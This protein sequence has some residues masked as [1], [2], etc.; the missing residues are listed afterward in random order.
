LAKLV[1]VAVTWAMLKPSPYFEGPLSWRK[2]KGGGPILINLIHDIDN[3]RYIC[4][5]IK[6]VYAMASHQVRSF[7]VEDTASITLR[8]ENGALGTIFLS[9]CAPSLSAYEATTAETPYIYGTDTENCYHFFGTEASLAF[10]R[11]KRLFYSD[12][13]KSAWNY[14]LSEE[15][16]TVVREED[17]IHREIQA[18]LRS[19]FGKRDSTNLGEDG[20]KTLEVTLA[21]GR[22][23]ETGRSITLIHK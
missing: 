16:I 20:R 19:D 14:P 22:S 9:D 12:P 18:F 21:A 4:G 15:K 11:M 6:E 7:P 3:M 17:L 13:A 23:A 8:F 2:E 1:G 10:P 5:E